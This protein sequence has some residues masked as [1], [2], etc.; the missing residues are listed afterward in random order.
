MTTLYSL[1]M[2][3]YLNQCTSLSMLVVTMTFKVYIKQKY[4]T[5]NTLSCNWLALFYTFCFVSGLAGRRCEEC[6]NIECRIW[7]RADH[8]ESKTPNQGW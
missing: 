8:L 4:K 5:F 6:E 1:N 2:C 3:L 7:Y